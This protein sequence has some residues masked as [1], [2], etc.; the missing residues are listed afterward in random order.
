MI[1]AKTVLALLLLCS[2]RPLAGES[3][4]DRGE[5]YTG[6]EYQQAFANPTD[7]PKLPRVLLIGDSIS[8]GYTVPVRKLLAGK[9][10]VHRIPTNGQTAKY[11]ASQ[12]DTW[13][14][15]EKWDLI[16][17]NWGLWDLCYRSPKSKNQ[18]HRDKVHGKVSATPEQYRAHLEV[19]VVR[20]KATGATLVWAS[21]TPVPENEA[22]RIKGDE[23]VYNRIAREVMEKH[24]VAIDDLHA[25]AM[26]KLPGIAAK[27]GDVHFTPAGYSFLAEQVASEISSRLR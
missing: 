17:F 5:L 27:P 20:L 2:A 1:P 18:G 23:L 13:L 7:D 19:A 25:R 26:R 11:G 8:I 14:G 21:T 9:A 16:H 3:L 15:K 24:G 4:A 12:L 10:N 22:G 6:K